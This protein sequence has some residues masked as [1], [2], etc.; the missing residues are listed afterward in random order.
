M[1]QDITEA[2]EWRASRRQSGVKIT[3]GMLLRGTG[4]PPETAAL[5]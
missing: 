1:D 3:S 2:A 4:V 5:F